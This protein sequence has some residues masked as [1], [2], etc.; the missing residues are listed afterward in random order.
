MIRRAVTPEEGGWTPLSP[1]DY[2]DDVQP[3]RRSWILRASSA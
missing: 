2:R 1:S 3:P